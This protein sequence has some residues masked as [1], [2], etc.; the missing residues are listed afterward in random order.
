MYGFF[1]GL[2]L[3]NNII[4]WTPR[5][6]LPRWVRAYILEAPLGRKQHNVAFR[7]LGVEYRIPLRFQSFVIL[8][9]FLANI[10]PLCTFYR[11][12]D[13]DPL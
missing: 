7:F 1:V 10:V 9:M 13:D 2:I 12:D 5:R 4:E 6:W 8:G 3:V 11:R